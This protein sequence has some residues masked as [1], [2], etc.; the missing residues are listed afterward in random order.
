MWAGISGCLL[1]NKESFEIAISIHDSVYNTDFSST[2]LPYDAAESDKQTEIIESHI[3][4]SLRKFSSEHLC[5]FLGAGVTLSLLREVGSFL[6]PPTMP[7]LKPPR[8][9][10]SVLA[11]GWSSISSPSCSISNLITR[12][13][14]LAPLSSIVSDRPLARLRPRALRPLLSMSIP[15][16]LGRLKNFFLLVVFSRSF[17][18][19][20]Q[21][22]SRRTPLRAKLSCIMALAITHACPSVPATKSRWMLLG[23]FISSTI[24]T[25]TASRLVKVPGMLLFGSPMSFVK[26]N[27][28]LASFLLHH[29]AVS[30]APFS[31]ET[32]TLNS[33]ICPFPIFAT[34][35][36]CQQVVLLS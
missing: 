10:I 25:C 1:P 8:P 6:T 23:R 35:A 21:L 2:I 14:P 18:C 3:I 22:T 11:C 33:S 27:S 19:N 7:F 31:H 32:L 24:S 4:S 5:K 12:T 17:L 26:K 29:K 13:R 36:S 9:L 15:P 34:C 20:V 30:L 16:S 28:R